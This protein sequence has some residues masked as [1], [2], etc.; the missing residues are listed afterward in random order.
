VHRRW[1]DVNKQ[2]GDGRPGTI[3]TCD[4]LL[5]RQMLYPTE[6]RALACVKCNPIFGLSPLGSLDQGILD[7]FHPDRPAAAGLLLVISVTGEVESDAEAVFALVHIGGSVEVA[8][9]HHEFCGSRNFRS[10]PQQLRK[11]RTGSAIALKVNLCGGLSRGP[12]T[13]RTSIWLR[14]S[15]PLLRS[16][17]KTS[18]RIL[19]FE[20]ANAENSPCSGISPALDCPPLH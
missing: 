17:R 5:R 8:P 2:E 13:K 6:L 19:P 10:L 7:E 16:H 3:R 20:K 12:R 11:F 18:N 9:A 1:R 15:V 14:R 4:P